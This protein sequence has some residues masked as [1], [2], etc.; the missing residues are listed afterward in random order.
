M[1]SVSLSVS[2]VV[3]F[4]FDHMDTSRA[5]KYLDHWGRWVRWCNRIPLETYSSLDDDFHTFLEL[6]Y[7]EE[8]DS[9]IRHFLAP[10]PRVLTRYYVDPVP[11]KPHFYFSL[12]R[13]IEQKAKTERMSVGQFKNA[14]QIG[15]HLFQNEASR[16]EWWA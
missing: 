9:I 2:T 6:G 13:T 14:L 1:P 11:G 5:V 4:N 7:E 3:S 8:A 12:D 10:F 16:K 15:R